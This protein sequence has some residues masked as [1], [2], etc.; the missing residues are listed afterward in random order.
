MSTKHPQE[1]AI[2]IPVRKG[3]GRC[4][5]FNWVKR[6]KL[7]PV[8]VDLADVEPVWVDLADVEPVWVESRFWPVWDE[9]RFWPVWVESRCWP[10]WVESR[11]WHQYELRADVDTSMSWEQMLTPVWVES[12]CWLPG[13][14]WFVLSGSLLALLSVVSKASG[15][16]WKYN[17]YVV[18]YTLFIARF[19]PTNW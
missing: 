12:R 13:I 10:V 5:F 15:C 2:H 1:S 17:L 8:W 19:L 6:Q 3:W 4:V 9:S 11:C 7:I 14:L 18:L 16:G